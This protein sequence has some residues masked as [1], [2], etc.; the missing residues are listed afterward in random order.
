MTRKFLKDASTHALLLI[1]LLI[2][3]VLAFYLLLPHSPVEA[4]P[5]DYL[6]SA[7][8]L[9]VG[10]TGAITFNVPVRMNFTH[11]NKFV[12]ISNATGGTALLKFNQT[13]TNPSTLIT[14]C[15]VVV[16]SGTIYKVDDWLL[17]NSIDLFLYHGSYTTNV[18]ITGG[19]FAAAGWW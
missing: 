15:H 7:G 3:A 4:R 1:L 17:V 9:A 19:L 16:P 2:A 8:E 12:R 14:D 10:T 6:S 18:A 13:S 5:V 11:A